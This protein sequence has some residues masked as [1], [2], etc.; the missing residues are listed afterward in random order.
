MVANGVPLYRGAQMAVDTTLVSP[1]RRNGQPHPRAAREAGVALEKARSRK[2]AVYPELLNARRC[3]LVV[4]AMEVGG[5]W[6]KEA[7]VFLR[8]LAKARARRAPEGL[9]ST[10]ARAFLSRWSAL[11]AM[12]AQRTFAA[13]LC[14][15]PLTG[16]ACVDGAAL[17]LSEV[18]EA[19]RIAPDVSHLGR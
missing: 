9:R 6:S 16:A 7:C 5:R 2:E 14:E 1:I 13:S 12:A 8:Q 18:L 3:K 4:L 19:S 17:D 15:E 11:L 10:T